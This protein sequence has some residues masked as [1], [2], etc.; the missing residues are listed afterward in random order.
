MNKKD[1]KTKN[2]NTPSSDDSELV[3]KGFLRSYMTE[4]RSEFKNELK[5]ELNSDF[6]RHV[7]ALIEDNQHKHEQ[8]IESFKMQYEM[9]ARYT[10]GNE[11]DRRKIHKRL[12]RLESKVLL[13]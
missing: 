3:T 13:A 5:T 6:Q 9:F 7:G 12:D 11:E 10:D 4:F 1:L 2:I 8:L